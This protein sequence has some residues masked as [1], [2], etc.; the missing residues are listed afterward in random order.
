M[1]EDEQQMAHVT[2]LQ[3]AYPRLF[4]KGSPLG[5]WF[6]PGWNAIL[7][8]L[9]AGIDSFLDDA[10]AGQF[11]VEQ[12]KEKFGSLRFYYSF[13]GKSKLTVDVVRR[14]G[15]VTASTAPR[16]RKPFPAPAVD[17]LVAEAERQSAVTCANCGAPGVLRKQGW[18]YVSCDRCEFG[19]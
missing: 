10:Q 14:R 1:N 11:R 9:C 6:P 16:Y 3:H 19:P 12:V 8:S 15:H 18:Y 4:Q 13:A 5:I 7:Y 2:A 17:A